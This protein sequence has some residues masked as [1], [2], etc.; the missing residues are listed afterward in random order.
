VE[1]IKPTRD[2][3]CRRIRL[4]RQTRRRLAVVL[5]ECRDQMKFLS[6]EGDDYSCLTGLA[7]TGPK[8]AKFLHFIVL[9]S[10]C[11]NYAGPNDATRADQESCWILSGL[12]AFI[13]AMESAQTLAEV[14][15]MADEAARLS[16]AMARYCRRHTWPGPTNLTH[17]RH[18][19]RYWTS[20]RST[21]KTSDH[22]W[23]WNEWPQSF[24]HLTACPHHA[25]GCADGANFQAFGPE[26]LARVTAALLHRAF[27][28][29]VRRFME[30]PCYDAVHWRMETQQRFDQNEF[31][32]DMVLKQGARNDTDNI[33]TVGSAAVPAP[34]GTG[35]VALARGTG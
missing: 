3:N 32:V 15:D 35:Y 8:W 2:V 19:I 25:W 21:W 17:L 4:A 9:Q 18:T 1:D 13:A 6:K 12:R 33:R 22:G 30:D 7:R 31:I 5:A 20:L 28:R 26:D 29:L 23:A 27:G 34:A 24:E 10:Q 16:G 14:A 11:F